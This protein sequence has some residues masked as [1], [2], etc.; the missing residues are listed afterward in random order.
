MVEST[1]PPSFAI[2]GKLGDNTNTWV[3]G[4]VM[5]RLMNGDGQ[6]GGR[7]GDHPNYKSIRDIEPELN[8]DAT[9][10]Y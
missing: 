1:S 6:G 2:T 5:I 10:R 4:A 8:D 7:S 3:I 9:E